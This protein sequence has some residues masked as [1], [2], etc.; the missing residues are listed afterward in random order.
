MVPGRVRRGAGSPP[1]SLGGRR[2]P[3]GDIDHFCVGVEDFEPD[4]V[5]TAIREAGLDN[6]LRVGSDNVSVHDPEGIRVQI[7]WPYWGG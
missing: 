5:A 2:S 4:R 6:D 1:P 3:S 7:S